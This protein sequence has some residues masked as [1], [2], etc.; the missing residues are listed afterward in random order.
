MTTVNL[1]ALADTGNARRYT[2]G[3]WQTAQ[4]QIYVGASWSSW[5]DFLVGGIGAGVTISSAI[6]S[7]YC[8]ATDSTNASFS[9]TAYLIK[10]AGTSFPT[11]GVDAASRTLSAGVSKTTN[12]RIDGNI[13]QTW[14]VTAD[15]QSLVNLG[16]WS[17][18]SRFMATIQS[19]SPNQMSLL[20]GYGFPATPPKL[21]IVY[22]AGGGGGSSYPPGQA[23]DNAAGYAG[24]RR[25][26]VAG[27]L[28]LGGF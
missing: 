24:N 14:D 13:Y 1:T 19:A 6:L 17:A 2:D 4:A 11:T 5:F 16:G 27:G 9:T 28:N 22:T 15:V 3:T 12:P 8:S 25:A 20:S 26:F 23:V 10:E 21:D 7:A 18:A